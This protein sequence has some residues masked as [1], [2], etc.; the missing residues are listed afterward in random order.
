MLRMAFEREVVLNIR[1]RLEMQEQQRLFGENADE[2]DIPSEMEFNY[3]H[4][5]LGSRQRSIL[6]GTYEK[7]LEEALGFSGFGDSLAKFL[8]EYASV[9]VHGS[10]FEGDGFEGHQHCIFHSKVIFTSSVFVLVTHQ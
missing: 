5:H 3:S 7:V 10:D 4:V 6:V 2:V 8:R 1:H 9:D